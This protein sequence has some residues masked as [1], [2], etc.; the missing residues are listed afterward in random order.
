[1]NTELISNIQFRLIDFKIWLQSKQKNLRLINL[2]NSK[3]K[4]RILQYMS[5]QDHAEVYLATVI[6]INPKNILYN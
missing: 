4:E 3:N 1:M 5:N 6:G 2:L